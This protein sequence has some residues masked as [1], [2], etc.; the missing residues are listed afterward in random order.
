VKGASLV[1]SNMFLLSFGMVPAANIK[2]AWD[3][4][5]DWGL[6]KIGDYG[7]FWYQVSWLQV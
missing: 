5:A 2:D 3:V 6:E 4:V 1:M 7:A